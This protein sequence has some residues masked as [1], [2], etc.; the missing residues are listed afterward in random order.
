MSQIHMALL[1]SLS[2]FAGW[3]L[4]GAVSRCVSVVLHVASWASRLHTN[5]LG[6]WSSMKA[7]LN[8]QTFSKPLLGSHF[9]S[10]MA[11]PRV[12]EEATA[13]EHEDH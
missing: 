10:H 8:V 12:T 13:Q 5:S 4:A 9:A 7:S 11:K 1:A 6:R 2:A 3:P